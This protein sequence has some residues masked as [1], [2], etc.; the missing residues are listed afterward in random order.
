MFEITAT[1]IC[2]SQ[3]RIS[4]TCSVIKMLFCQDNI[5]DIQMNKS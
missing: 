1:I 2:T 4:G 5:L 3:N